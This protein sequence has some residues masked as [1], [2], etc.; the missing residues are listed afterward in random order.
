MIL[1]QIIS[2]IL[3]VFGLF[4][5]IGT[6]LYNMIDIQ[7]SWLWCSEKWQ[8]VKAELIQLCFI[9]QENSTR[10]LGLCYYL[11]QHKYWFCL[12]QNN[13]DLWLIW[14]TWSLWNK[15]I[16]EA[17]LQLYDQWYWWVLFT[18]ILKMN[19]FIYIV[20]LMIELRV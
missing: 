9:K 15:G 6:N 17:G 3:Y 14:R 5:C 7:S 18:L 20:V 2:Y 13:G 8:S 1:H 12:I 11:D 10:F 19:G 16:H 4:K